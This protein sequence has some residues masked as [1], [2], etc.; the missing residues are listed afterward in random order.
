MLPVDDPT[1]SYWMRQPSS[2]ANEGSTGSLPAECDIAII[3][4]GYAGSMCAYYLQKHGFSGSLVMLEARTAC[5]GATGR[6]GGFFKPAM[7]SS[8]KK[9]RDL[10]GPEGAR[11]QFDFEISHITAML[12]LVS[13]EK[14]DCE[15]RVLP[16][17]DVCMTKEQYDFHLENLEEAKVAGIDVSQVQRVPQETAEQVTNVRG[18]YG[19]LTRPAATLSPYKLI[20]TILEKC[21]GRGLR[22]FTNAPVHSSENDGQHTVLK[23]SRGSIKARKVIYCTNGYSGHILPELE[24]IVTPVKGAVA[25][26]PIKDSTAKLNATHGLI[27]TLKDNCYM[28]QHQE[29]IVIGGAKRVLIGH[30][31]RWMG[32]GDD[33]TLIPESAEYLDSVVSES[34][35][36]P[37]MSGIKND[38]AWSGIMGYTKD[39]MPYIG[40]RSGTP[41]EFLCLGFNGHGTISVAPD[42]HETNLV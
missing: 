10:Y 3:G 17:Y 18:C 34:V 22:L 32:V 1:S 20:T 39:F 24:S 5:S 38:Y 14:I 30:E 21:I 40:Q 23:T 11:E 12:E 9:Y 37:K 15:M 41:N 2:V 35:S 25:S 19:A 16:S 27:W 13:E 26:Y 36:F 31:D 42:N 6:N 7:Y 33:S 8:F 28:T 4:S 29:H